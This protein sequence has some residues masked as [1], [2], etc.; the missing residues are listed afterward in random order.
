MAKPDKREMIVHA[1][2]ELIAEHGFH[3]APMALIAERGG[4]AAGT[5][6]RYFDSKDTLVNE[7]YREFE[8]KIM[9]FLQTG[10]STALPIRERFIHLGTNLLR[11]FIANPL[12]FRFLE[13]FHN[14]PYGVAY[15][16]DMILGQTGNDNV[17]KNLFE[18]GVARQAIKNFPAAALHALTFGPLLALARDHILGFVKLDDDLIELTVSACWDGMKL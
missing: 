9:V 5:I 18:E 10:Y 14:S 3:G 15:R 16:R 12:V 7:I 13:Q 1:A 4:V 2:L 11:Y 8:E 17:Y 6:Y